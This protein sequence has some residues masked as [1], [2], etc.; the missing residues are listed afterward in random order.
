M[1][2][3]KKGGRPSKYRPEFC[4]QA[5]KLCRLGAIDR[6]IA[7]FFQVSEST[8]NLW[9]LKHPEFSESLKR[10]RDEIDSQVE[11][12]L[13]HRAI[14]YSHR[15]EKVFQFQ[16]QVIRAKTVEHY[17]PDVAAMIFWLKNRKPGEWRQTPIDPD[18]DSKPP[19]ID[20]D[21]DIP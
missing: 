17:P 11:R 9:K 6:N 10:S 2:K 4:E 20:E 8:L 1:A 3:E 18:G 12:S 19:L 14:G 16:G 5:A 15:S 21:S 13:F 7:D